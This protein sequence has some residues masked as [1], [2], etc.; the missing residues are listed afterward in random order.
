MKQCS[1]FNTG[2]RP[3]SV[4]VKWDGNGKALQLCS[5][6]YLN[7]GCSECASKM[8]AVHQQR[9]KM[10]QTTESL[11]DVSMPKRLL[12]SRRT[13]SGSARILYASGTGI[14]VSLHISDISG[15]CNNQLRNDFIFYVKVFW[16]SAAALLW[17]FP[18]TFL[19]EITFV[20]CIFVCGRLEKKLRLFLCRRS[21]C[22]ELKISELL[23]KL[24]GLSFSVY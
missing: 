3:T 16:P 22:F 7:F 17:T 2:I 11:N 1:V 18:Q 10:L 13:E 20:Y 21:E 8:E 4:C 14:R 24:L 19:Q 15:W 6:W 5:C 23:R 12:G 9:A